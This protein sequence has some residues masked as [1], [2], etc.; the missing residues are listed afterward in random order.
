[1]E[2][3]QIAITQQS[4]DALHALL[5]ACA[6]EGAETFIK[7]FR[8]HCERHGWVWFG[9]EPKQAFNRRAMAVFR[10][11]YSAGR[12]EQLREGRFGWWVFRADPRCPDAHQQLNGLAVPPDH[13]FWRYYVPPLG[14]ECRC[15]LVGAHSSAAL[16]CSGDPDKPLPA[17]WNQPDPGTGLRPGV[18][19]LWGGQEPP[20][21]LALLEAVFH[22][23]G[24]P[25]G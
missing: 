22:G 11:R 5:D 13:E 8:A 18:D 9:L 2:R 16:R 7:R 12:L 14:W 25:P 20:A 23:E 15:Y 19:R 21:L 1:M 3:S 24:V 4:L 6:N 10:S 17:W